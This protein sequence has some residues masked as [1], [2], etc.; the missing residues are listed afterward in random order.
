LA[1]TYGDTRL[2]SLK[3]LDEY[4]T[5]GAVSTTADVTV[6]IQNFTNDALADLAATVAK[7][8]GE[9]FIPH[10]PVLNTLTSDTSSIKTFLPGGADISVSL[11]NAKA[12]FFEADGPGSA[13]TEE[14]ADGTTYTNLET[15]TIASTVTSFTEYRRLITPT[16]ATNTVRLRFTGLYVF[17]VRNYI[18]YPYAW[19]TA[20]GVQQNRPCFEYSLPS[21]FLDM[22]QVMIKKDT[23]QYVPYQTYSLRPDGIITINRYDAPAEVMIHYWRM[24][25]LFTFTGVEATDDA[26]KYGIDTVGATYR[27]T[28]DAT[29]VLPY[30]VAAQ[31]FLSMGS[32]YQSIGML[33]LN[34]YEDKKSKLT[35]NK[36]GYE[37]SNIFGF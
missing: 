29:L 20:A 11:L 34:I 22:A 8:H 14:T 15:I 30:Y 33:L 24:P 26:Q 36:Y 13:I 2:Q 32:S 4:S 12:C 19:A 7:I 37:S 6:K 10:A 5:T 9:Y 28:D 27:I 35:G 1:R 17:H 21:D 16:L 25:T 3:L 23:R 31:I 18:L